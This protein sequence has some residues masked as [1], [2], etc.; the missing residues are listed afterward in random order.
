LYRI[1]S[2]LKNSIYKQKIQ[3]RT[4][5]DM[6]W[7]V[8]FAGKQLQVS[9]VKEPIKQGNL[10]QME[11]SG[12]IKV[13]CD[14]HINYL[15]R[16]YSV[17]EK[18]IGVKVSVTE[19]EGQVIIHQRGNVMERHMKVILPGQLASTREHHLSPWKMALEINSSYRRN[20]RPYGVDV[21]EFVIAVIKRG[22]GVIDVGTIYGVLNMDK[23]HSAFAI[24]EACKLALEADQPTYRAVKVFLKLLPSRFAEK[25]LK[26]I[27]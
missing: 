17:D 11:S 18:Y 26:A 23:T 21:E 13:R 3:I 1:E 20:A 15:D 6:T 8:F 25:R 5:Q 19:S 4:Y 22:C 2:D 9:R 10:V 27:G 16:Y 24:N 12:E 7:K 14:G